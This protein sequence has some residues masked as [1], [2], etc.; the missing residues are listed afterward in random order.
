M[1]A[2]RYPITVLDLCCGKGGDQLKW[3]EANVKHVTFIDISGDSVAICRQRYQQLC[4]RRRHTYTADFRVWDCSEQFPLDY[5]ISD[6]FDLVS[7]QF[8]LHYGFETCNQVG[9]LL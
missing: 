6:H 9:F 8:S 3:T 7:C 2:E 5:P 4:N 1:G